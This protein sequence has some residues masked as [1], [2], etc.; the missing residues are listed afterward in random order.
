MTSYWDDAGSS[1]V[2]RAYGRQ[3]TKIEGCERRERTFDVPVQFGGRERRD[4]IIVGVQ[5]DGSQR[6]FPI[7]LVAPRPDGRARKDSAAHRGGISR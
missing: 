6:H 2:V 4:L 5:S 1:I 7:T 3:W